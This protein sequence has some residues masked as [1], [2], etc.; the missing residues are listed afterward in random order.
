MAELFT[1]T[2]EVTYADGDMLA[3]RRAGALNTGLRKFTLG[4]LSNYVRSKFF[5]ALTGQV[6]KT[7]VVN[8]AETGF[9]FITSGNKY[10]LGFSIEVTTPGSNEVLLRHV[11]TA[12]VT[13]ADDF[14]L[15]VGRLR[16]SGANPATAQSFSILHNASAIGSMTI[17][18]AGVVT[19]ATT[20][21]ALA[22][23]A[24][25]ELRIDAPAAPDANIVGV[26]V[27]LIGTE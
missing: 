18:T 11:F 16:P 14:A 9:D 15:S 27:T 23:V 12:P 17:S 2:D 10:R 13:F 21:G 22:V 26:S 19:F 24:G 5:G 25:D 7:P 6:G 3:G 1:A 20:G 8:V 4:N